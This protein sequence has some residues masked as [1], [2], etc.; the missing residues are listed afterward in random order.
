MKPEQF[1]TYMS[2]EKKQDDLPDNPGSNWVNVNDVAD[3]HVRALEVPEASGQR[4]LTSAGPYSG[5]DFA[6]FLNENYPQLKNVPKGTPGI[7]EKLSK[8]VNVADGAKATR[9]L[10]IHYRS[11]DETLKGMAKDL[12]QF[13]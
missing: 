6:V 5:N 1:W 7:K 2:G 4:F 11:L 9:V 13:L 3:A 12:E 10:G 8:E